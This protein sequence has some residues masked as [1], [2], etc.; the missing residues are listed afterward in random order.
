MEHEENLSEKVNAND[1]SSARILIVEDDENLLELMNEAI[2]AAG[3]HTKMVDRAKDA[4]EVVKSFKPHL[5]VTDNDMP[6]MTGL[7]ML[8]E[9]RSQKNYVSVIFVSGRTDTN[10][11]VD[12]LRAGANDYIR[13][14]FRFEELIARIECSLRLNEVHGELLEAN[15]K[16]HDMVDH[17]YL[18]GLFNMRSMYDKIDYE[19]KR[20]RRQ[21]SQVA[22]I[23]LDMD[24]FKRVN[25]EH[26]HLFGSHVLKAMGRLIAATMR[27]VDLAARYGGDEYLIVLTDTGEEGAVA[28]AERLRKVVES[29][30]FREGQHTID[31][32]ISVGVAL[33][34]PGEEDLDA[35]SLVR[36]AD[37]ALYQ[38]KEAGR[39]KVIVSV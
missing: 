5:V 34:I 20:A 35:R 25:D 36:Q 16:L 7:Q 38:A 33:S 9:F 19:L 4:L 26:D 17:D 22:A 12:A 18:T 39:N 15:Q 37:A 27:E 24:H 2:S 29:H 30:T 10:Y 6:G 28:F 32:T 14:P 13:K 21:K 11:V 23:M 3:Y 8:K 1:A 31:L